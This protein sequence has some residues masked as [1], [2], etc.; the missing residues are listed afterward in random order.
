LAGR[1]VQ[2]AGAISAA[3]IALLAD[4]TREE[5][6]TKAMAVIGVGIGFIFMAAAKNYAETQTYE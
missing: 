2:G 4:L 5:Q 6:R 1:L 3:V